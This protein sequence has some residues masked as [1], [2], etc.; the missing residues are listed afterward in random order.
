MSHD[1]RERSIMT[2]SRLTVAL[3]DVTSS[4]FL[5]GNP[6]RVSIT[7]SSHPT[8]RITVRPSSAVTID[9]GITI[10][11]ASQPLTITEYEHGDAIRSQWFGVTV[12]LAAN[13]AALETIIPNNQDV[14]KTKGK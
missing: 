5:Q 12:V 1:S 10:P 6:S 14:G 3:I 7:F 13:F 8:Q 2:Q 4:Q 11:A 9:E